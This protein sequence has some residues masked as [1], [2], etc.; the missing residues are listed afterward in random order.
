[1]TLRKDDK[2]GFRL[3]RKSEEIT[4]DIFRLVQYAEQARLSDVMNGVKR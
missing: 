4:V 1:M 3:E 2:I